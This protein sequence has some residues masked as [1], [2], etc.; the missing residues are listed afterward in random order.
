MLYSVSSI[1]YSFSTMQS[2][3]Y[4]RWTAFLLAVHPLT[5]HTKDCSERKRRKASLAQSCVFLNLK[6]TK[7]LMEYAGADKLTATLLMSI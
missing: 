7:L 5:R 3:L 2:K 4:F 6:L 1:N